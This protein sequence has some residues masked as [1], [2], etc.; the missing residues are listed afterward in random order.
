MHSSIP[1]I[2]LAAGN[3]SR[4]YPLCSANHKALITLGGIS[5]LTRTVAAV[6]RAGFGH[7]VL[8]VNPNCDQASLRAEVEQVAPGVSLSFVILPEATGMGEAV[9]A[10]QQ[11]LTE[12][13]FFVIAPYHFE[14][15]GVMNQFLALNQ[16]AVISTTPTDTPWEYGIVKIED[17]KAVGIV[18]KPAQGTEPSNQ[19]VQACYLLNQTFLSI[20]QTT[21]KTHYS[22]EAALDNLMQQSE[23]GLI[24][25]EKPLPSL[26]YPW[27]L[28]DFQHSILHSLPQTQVDSTAEIAPTA[29]LD[30]SQGAIV[31]EAGAKVGHAS[32]VV[33]PCYIGQN[34]FIGDFS[35]I[36]ESSIESDSTI[37][38]NTEVARSIIL[39]NSSIHFGYL[40]DSI[41]DQHV[42][43]GAGLV[44]ANKRLDRGLITVVRDQKKIFSGKKTLGVIMGQG[45]EVGIKVGT[46]PGVLIGPK[47]KIFPG[48]VLFSSTSAEEVVKS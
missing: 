14:A 7:Q 31:I 28:F 16:P 38:A 46:M 3:S 48:T 12:E 35:L 10:A 15:V 5:L 32:R 45:A 37:G 23:V 21:E 41:L 36:R 1:V 9:L 33:G 11:Y 27:N 24:E 4:M 18:E 13:Q 17:G 34:V 6:S 39:Q 29:V 42:K 44:T 20:L 43:V 22:F 8:V 47:S 19:K 40:A 30:D 25:L 26:K 2:I